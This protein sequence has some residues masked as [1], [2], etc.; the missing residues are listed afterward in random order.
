MSQHP[1]N[2]QALVTIARVRRAWG[3]RGEVLAELFTDF[4]ERLEETREVLLGPR[5][6]RLE[7]FRLHQGGVVLKFAGIDNIP[8]AQKLAGWEVRVPL[9][10]R[11]RLP[12]SSVY[13]DELPGCRVVERGS[14][15]GVVRHLDPTVGTPVLVVDTPGGELLVPF[16]EEICRRVDVAGRVIEVELPDGLRGL[17]R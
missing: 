16:A 12:G 6:A 4:P 15:L 17:T 2:A 7:Q 13:W 1:A 11:R 3:R 5:P 14:Q 9:A 8:S 10:Q